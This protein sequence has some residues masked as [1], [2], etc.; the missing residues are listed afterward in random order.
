MKNSIVTYGIHF[1]TAELKVEGLLG[2]ELLPGR[3]GLARRGAHLFARSTVLKPALN[4]KLAA[5]CAEAV[6]LLHATVGTTIV[7]LKTRQQFG[8]PI[9]RV[10]ALQLQPQRSGGN[11][12]F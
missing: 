1:C 2:S 10:Q 4:I 9:E 5:L 12:F 3:P 7:Y 8:K 6:G 11:P